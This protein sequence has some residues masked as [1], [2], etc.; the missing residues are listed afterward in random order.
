VGHC[1]RPAATRVVCAGT[2][3]TNGDTSVATTY[4]IKSGDTLSALAVQNKT[5]VAELQKANAGTVTDPNK[6]VAGKTLNIP[7]AASQAT[8]G[9]AATK[10]AAPAPA[11]AAAPKP[12]PRPAPA[13]PRTSTGTNTG[14]STSTSVRIVN[15][16]VTV[17]VKPAPGAATPPVQEQPARRPPTTATPTAPAPGGQTAPAPGGQAAPSP[18]TPT[19]TYTAPTT[20]PAAPAPIPAAPG[21]TNTAAPAAPAA[22]S[23]NVPIAP[24]PTV[25]IAPTPTAAAAPAPSQYEDHAFERRVVDLVNQI[26]VQQGLRALAYDTRLDAAAEQH[27]QHMTLVDQMAHDGIGDGTPGERIAANG[28]VNAWGENVAV[29]QTTAEQVV[30]EWMASPG[31]RANI[32]NP[33]FSHIGVAVGVN[34]AGRPYWAQEFGVGA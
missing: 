7:T 15:D 33:T 12:A 3:T 21:S 9:A 2:E 1:L 28:F 6:I 24:D 14:A 5:T 17:T 32:L 34:A 4:T 16:E 31:H 19:Y 29:G 18:A 23:P 13:A 11:A 27:T 26:R 20:T 22:P 25:P 8:S 30:Q 10:P